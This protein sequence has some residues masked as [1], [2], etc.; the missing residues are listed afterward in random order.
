M[1]LTL[2]ICSF[3]GKIILTV[4]YGFLSFQ[5]L[6]GSTFAL[7]VGLQTG[8][9]TLEN[10]VWRLL[11]NLKNRTT[12]QSSNCTT[13]YLPKGYKNTDSKGHMHSDVYRSIISNSQTMERAQMS[14]AW[15]MNKENMVYIYIQWTITQPSK[16]KNEILP[17]AMMW[18]ELESIM[19]SKISQSEKD[20]YHMISLIWGI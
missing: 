7:L 18:M 15:W 8:V 5:R 14:I 12:L 1:N 19:L 3:C 9:A 20:K 10:R 6:V 4:I 17:F 13:R 16:R 11:K 2:S